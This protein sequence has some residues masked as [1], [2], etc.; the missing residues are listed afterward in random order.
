MSAVPQH[1]DLTPEQVT[2]LTELTHKTQKS[3]QE[4]VGDALRRYSTEIPAT[5]AIGS[6][7]FDRLAQDGLIGCLEG[8]P[9]DL[10]TNAKYMEGFG[11]SR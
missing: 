9:P 2:L 11:E 1:L 7:L 5:A 6:S 8:A 10:S 4:V 3:A